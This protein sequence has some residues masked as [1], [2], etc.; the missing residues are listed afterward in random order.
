MSAHS[1][2]ACG[3]HLLRL[4]L[5]GGRGSCQLANDADESSMAKLQIAVHAR[6]GGLL[7]AVRATSRT[8]G[9]YSFPGGP[10]CRPV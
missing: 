4:F 8:G 2:D 3:G 5:R 9:D 7:P 6:F 1:Q 10:R